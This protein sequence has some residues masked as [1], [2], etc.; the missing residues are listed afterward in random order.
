MESS[1]L[2]NDILLPILT[3]HTAIFG[4]INRIEK[5]VYKMTNHTLQIVKLLVYKSRESGTLEL[6]RLIN[7]IKKVKL[8][9]K[10]WV[11]HDV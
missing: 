2:T 11:Q 6:S 4:F 7:E 5:S 1:S 10:N 8:L 3:P 9:L